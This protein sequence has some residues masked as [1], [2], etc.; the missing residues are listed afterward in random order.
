VEVPLLKPQEVLKE[1][2]T[3]VTLHLVPKCTSK[4]PKKFQTQKRV[5]TIQK[6]PEEN[7]WIKCH[8]SINQ[9]LKKGL[10]NWWWI[11]PNGDN[12]LTAT[13]PLT[14]SSSLHSLFRVLCTF[15]TRYL[16]TLGFLQVFSFGW[17]SSPVLRLH[18]QTARLT[19]E[20]N[21]W[22]PSAPKPRS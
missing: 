19:Q 10:L 22:P 11:G 4:S 7:Q 18:F 17:R 15:P 9:N 1:P 16:C 8:L 20:T 14:I 5:L 6:Y 13:F 2:P 21:T 3:T 12:E